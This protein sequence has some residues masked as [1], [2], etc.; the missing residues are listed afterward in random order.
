MDP[1]DIITIDI[2]D[3]NF[4]DYV[5]LPPYTMSTC[6]WDTVDI[7]ISD[8]DDILR[9]WEQDRLWEDIHREAKSNT[10]LQQA[11]ERVKILYYLSKEDG[12]P[13]T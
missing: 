3:M 10:S 6:S 1:K 11:I 4:S 7:S 12:N 5:T 8:Y 13:K 2:S 9:D